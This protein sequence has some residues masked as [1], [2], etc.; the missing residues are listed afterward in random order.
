MI[1]E[2]HFI[3]GIENV[4]GKDYLE[5]DAETKVASGFPVL[6]IP[7]VDTGLGYV[8]PGGNMMG[9]T[10]LSYGEFNQIYLN[11]TGYFSQSRRGGVNIIFN[12]TTSGLATM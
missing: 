6:S 2:Q 9:N 11:D 3:T 4:G 8:G 1:F 7:M 12:S 10:Q 5:P